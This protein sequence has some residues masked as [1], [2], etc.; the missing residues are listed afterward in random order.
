MKLAFLVTAQRLCSPARTMN[1]IWAVSAAL[2]ALGLLLL[3]LGVY[4]QP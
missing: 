4:L 2:I 1:L 3:A